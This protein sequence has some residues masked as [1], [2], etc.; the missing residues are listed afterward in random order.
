MILPKAL[1]NESNINKQVFSLLVINNFS[2]TQNGVQRIDAAN[3]AL[4]TVSEVLSNQ[5]SNMLSS[6]SNNLDVG[7]NFR[8]GSDLSPAEYELALNYYYK[9]R[10]VFYT[11]VGVTDKTAANTKGFIGDFAVEYK[12]I[13]DGRLRLKA[14]N[15]TSDNTYLSNYFSPYIQGVGLSY[16][17]EF[18][19]LGEL[20]RNITQGIGVKRLNYVEKQKA[21]EE[22]VEI[23]LEVN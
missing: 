18:D 22:E 12:L 9:N 11:N 21:E 19:N 6:A 14:F 17:E 7:V 5:L 15:Q 8:P 10:L 23:P 16:R 13:K 20:W 2:R 1:S 4:S 3:S